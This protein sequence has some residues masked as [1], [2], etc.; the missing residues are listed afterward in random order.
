MFVDWGSHPVGVLTGLR[1]RGRTAASVSTVAVFASTL[2]AV[3]LTNDGVPTTDV[4]LNDSGIWVTRQQDTLV[5]RFNVAAKVVDGAVTLGSSQFDVMQQ[6]QRVV[7]RDLG[8]E[9]VSPIDPAALQ[10]RGAAGVPATSQISIGGPVAA[11]LDPLAGILWTLP[12]D[13]VASFSVDG[14]E[15]ALT[16][17][18]D[19]ALAV[20]RDGTVHVAAGGELHTIAPLG[21]GPGVEPV[22]TEL[23]A[24]PKDVLDVTTVG[25]DAVVLNRSTAELYLP[26][27]RA[28]DAPSAD[29][30]VLQQPGPRSGAVVFADGTDLVSQP[31][32]GGEATRLPS[33]ATGSPAA[34][35][36]LA[37]CAYGAWNGSQR[38]ARD[39]VGEDSDLVQELAG[40]AAG[41][42][43]YR[44]NHEHVILNELS[45]GSVWLAS[46]NYELFDDWSDVLPSEG[47]EQEEADAIPDTTRD[48]MLD[49][50]KENRPPV[51][52]NDSFGVRPGRST[53]LRV[54]DNDADPDGDALVASLDVDETPLGPVQAIYGGAALQVVVPDDA[55]G[56][57]T[58]AY[59]VD[60]G[61]ENGTDTASVRLEVHDWDRNDPPVRV[62]ERDLVVASGAEVT[63]RLLEDWADPNGDDLM[64]VGASAAT[65]GDEVR[66]TPDGELTFRDAGTEVGRKS[67]AITVS[68]GVVETEG[69]VWVEV[70]EDQQP[71]VARI[72]HATTVVGEPVVIEPLLNDSDPNGDELRL[73]RVDEA[74]PAQLAM[75][76]DAGTVTLTSDVARVYYLTYLVTDGPSSTLGLIRVDVVE[77]ADAVAPPVA[78]KDT[79][80][81]PAEGSVLVDVL[82]NDY[83]PAGGV[84]VL[85][86]VEVDPE[87][88]LSVEVVD[89]HLLRITA[90][91][92]L[93]GPVS[94]SYSVS[95]GLASAVGE[96]LV[97]P[98]PAPAV[99]RPPQANPDEAVVR[100][101]DIVTIPVLA[102]DEHP[103]NALIELAPDLI[104][105][106]DT[107]D[108]LVFT[109]N[110]TIR[111]HAGEN[112]RTVRAVYE[113]VDPQGQKDS[114]QVT[115]HIRPVDAEHNSPP[116]PRDLEARAL[117][118]ST[119]R[120]PVPLAGLDT[121]GDRVTL[122][123]LDTA[124]T[125]G[126]VV[127]VGPSWIDYEANATST[128]ADSFRYRVVDS[129]GA[130]ATASVTVGIA[131]A[132]DTNLAPIAVDDVVYVRPERLVAVP[133]LVN[134]VDPEGDQVRLVTDGLE[135]PEGIEARVER[136][137][138]LVR[139]PQEPGAY[140]LYYTIADSFRAEAVGALTLEVS[141]TA[142]LR[143]PV[144]IDDEFGVAEV[145]GKETVDVPVLDNDDDPDGF[146]DELVVTVPEDLGV[147]PEGLPLASVSPD[148][149][150]KVTLTE[151]AQIIPYTITDQDGLSASAFVLVPGITNLPPALRAEGPELSV[152][153]GEE[154]RVDLN[155]HVVVADGRTMAL[156]EAGKVTAVR[157]TGAAVD[158]QTLSFV[159]EEGYVG[160]AAISF[161]VAD[162]AQDDETTQSAVLSVPITV[163]PSPEAETEPELNNPPTARGASLAVEVGTSESL[164]LSPYGSDVDGDELTFAL[165]D[166]PSSDLDVTFEGTVLTVT[167]GNSV[168]KGTTGR[169]TF[170]VS[171]GAAEPVLAHVAIEVTSSRRPLATTNLDRREDVHQGEPV[172]IDVLANDNS[173]FPGEPL[174]LLHAEL[175]TGQGAVEVVGDDVVITPSDTFVGTLTA[176]YTVAD[177]TQDPDRNVDGRVEI[178]VLGR[179]GEMTAPT[180]EEVRSRTVVLSWAPPVNNGSVI[181]HYEVTASD[182]STFRCETTTCT[183]EGLTNNVEYTFMV[184]AHNDVGA[185]DPSPESAPARPDERPDP[186]AA[187]TLEFGD[188][189]LTVSWTNAV[190][191]DR[192][193]IV[194]VTLEI[195]PAPLSGQIQKPHVV[196]TSLVWDGLDNGTEYKVRVMAHNDAPEPSDFSPYSLGEIPAGVPDTPAAPS[197]SRIDT[198]LGGE[199]DVRWNEPANNGDA[200][201]GYQLDVL[202][203]GAVVRTVQV[204]GTQQTVTGLAVSGSYTFAVRASNK[205][206]SSE[207]S[208]RSEAITPFGRPGP[209]GTPRASLTSNTD[210]RAKVEWTA[211]APNGSPV[212]YRVRA[213]GNVVVDSTSATNVTVTGLTNGTAYRFTVEPVNAGGS[214]GQTA[215]SNA[216][217][218]YG[219]PPAPNLSAAR[220][221]DRKVTFSWSSGGTNGNPVQIQLKV[222]SGAWENVSA[223]GSRTVS[224][225]YSTTVTARVRARDTVDGSNYSSE[226]SR[227]ATTNPAPPPPQA[228]VWIT[229]GPRASSSDCPSCNFFVVHTENFSNPGTYSIACQAN[230]GSGW[231][232]FN[233]GSSHPIKANGTRQLYCYY[234]NHGLN[235]QVRVYFNGKAYGTMTW[236]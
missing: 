132:S 113:I 226:V 62:R 126:R 35:V 145:V 114:A 97:V 178:T 228:R 31:L 9:A 183:L 53:I 197:A 203:G 153:S 13:Q 18:D 144:A 136:D 166:R 73:A 208:G 64:L 127:S 151:D 124:P 171:D 221:G 36:F 161:E 218:P 79:A 2:V 155:E 11:I 172:T 180:V 167:A 131:P 111:F 200:I 146:V 98:V 33:G 74:P 185:S 168:P 63:A 58:F 229:Q 217:T 41:E 90:V 116:R 187:P 61:R 139:A 165:V 118:G 15:P 184:V 76:F 89:H 169:A 82:G 68:D 162:G 22:L 212:S 103:D 83:D 211:A 59:T 143:R 108:G 176:R 205:A 66:F 94:L 199:I 214:A 190:Y 71:P 233:D 80:L 17:L 196:G 25:Q 195:S 45:L 157:G 4:Q 220:D 122:R 75:D 209:A 92:A 198:P 213:N 181:T 3:A 202:E 110:D 201:A 222:G 156:T 206:G 235:H 138:V 26:G 8:G 81:M 56:T 177:A 163:L 12:S 10:L 142:P 29:S 30:I 95:N 91:R 16:G 216:V 93:Q 210:R 106:P 38:I 40:G 39:C 236:P 105:A 188:G 85:Q 170:S 160:P 227:S 193:P 189:E 173:P 182:G 186:P 51:A 215:Q 69:T 49:R 120:I 43:A 14:T 99:L 28:V 72:D 149:S 77:P 88:G 204:A 109:T 129:L 128:G 42:L 117:A 57:A 102:N 219:T 119:I 96:V 6:G 5:G 121:D 21:S 24:A 137:R 44:V 175:D 231:R 154:L 234:G 158:H 34:P 32:G 230:S 179:P 164:D 104:E 147:G 7:A 84:L 86:S 107:E 19:G 125:K 112:A 140:T 224:A 225:G 37:G 194:D 207:T 123:G 67:I 133:V 134:D 148:G 130:Q 100:A 135:V 223:S 141:G 192:S 20:S 159:S 115:I 55:N 78:V 27:G 152:L 70:V 52:E 50:D 46:E 101:G 65:R 87:A 232:T 47:Q 60:D 48:P 191:T 150:V 23:P 1:Q 174:V 54:L